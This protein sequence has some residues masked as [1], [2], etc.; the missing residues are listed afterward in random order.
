MYRLLALLLVIVVTAFGYGYYLKQKRPVPSVVQTRPT[1]PASTAPASTGQETHTVEQKSD[2]E[3]K[4]EV[5]KYI[6]SGATGTMSEAGQR[7]LQGIIQATV[8]ARLKDPG[9]AEFRGLTL[10]R[11]ADA[12]EPRYNLCGSVNARN[13]F[14]GYTGFQRFVSDGSGGGPV[15]EPFSSE[16]SG[17]EN[18]EQYWRS[19]GCPQ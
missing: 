19:V 16:R 3:A 9:S 6:Q 11:K 18:F 5:E 4:A 8:V 2:A 12:Y 17:R 13:S 7:M 15:F 14:G 1:S 10:V